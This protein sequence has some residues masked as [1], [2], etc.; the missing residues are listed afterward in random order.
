MFSKGSFVVIIVAMILEYILTFV[1]RIFYYIH[2]KKIGKTF[3]L[4]LP[5]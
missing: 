3:D 5:R 4:A 1:A 2:T